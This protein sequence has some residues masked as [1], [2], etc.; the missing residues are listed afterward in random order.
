MSYTEG[1]SIV[2]NAIRELSGVGI[3][4]YDLNSFFNYNVEGIKNNRGHYCD[5]CKRA[6]ELPNGK[7]NCEKSDKLEAVELA[8][9]Y[10]EPFFFEC[11]MG[12]RELVIPLHRDDIFLGII[13]VGQCRLDNDYESKI[14]ANAEKMHGDPDE[15]L[16]LYNLLPLLSRKDLMN[17][18][19]ILIQYFDTEILNSEIISPKI[20]STVVQKSL[21]E[22]IKQFIQINYKSPLSLKKIAKTLHVNASYASRC[23][24]SD[25]A[26]TVTEYIMY[27]RIER[28][29]MLLL[30]TDAPIGNIALNVGF[31]D[32]NYFSRIFKKKEGCSPLQYRK[33]TYPYSHKY[34]L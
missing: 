10:K 7:V 16:S 34:L 1:I 11:H 6:R 19:N 4:Y 26:M 25:C 13:F 20:S 27:V 31:E 8:K 28:A 33:N 32:A 17:I 3:C 12:M 9:Q 24:S 15:F 18:G 5:F 14:R 30:T 22:T 21:T 29:K 2:I 23:F